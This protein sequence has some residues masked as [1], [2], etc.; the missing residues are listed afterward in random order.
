MS[1]I[2]AK[3]LEWINFG[4]KMKDESRNNQN[5][6]YKIMKNPRKGRENDIKQMRDKNGIINQR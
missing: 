4:R 2:G 5:L 6:F 3:E 1:V